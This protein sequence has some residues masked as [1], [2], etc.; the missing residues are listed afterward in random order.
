MI[1]NAR[2]GIVE[3]DEASRESGGEAWAAAQK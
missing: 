3:K 1:S 2:D